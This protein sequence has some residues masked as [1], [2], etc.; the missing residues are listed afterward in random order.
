MSQKEQEIEKLER[1][2]KE[3]DEKKREIARKLKE[4]KD[5]SVQCGRV[6]TDKTGFR[7]L[8]ETQIRFLNKRHSETW[9][10]VIPKTI[11]D[12]GS[13]QRKDENQVKEEI[14]NLLLDL[15]ELLKKI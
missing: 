4:M 9:Q 3:I 7:I 10:T 12:K 2:I 8:C 15:E 11:H 6:K 5:D 1:Q 14:K 13:I